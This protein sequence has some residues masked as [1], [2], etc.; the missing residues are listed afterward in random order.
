[1]IEVMRRFRLAADFHAS[2]VWD[3][4][5]GGM[6]E[7]DALPIDDV[8][9]ARL[10]AWADRF[11]ATLDED[12]PL[13]SGFASTAEEQAWVADGRALAQELQAALGGDAHVAYGD[14]MGA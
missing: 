9:R 10:R 12:D 13:A 2:P 1:M 3:T 14:D 5:R 4:D 6:V 11:D 7:L 8:L